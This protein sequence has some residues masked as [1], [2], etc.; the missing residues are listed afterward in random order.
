MLQAVEPMQVDV[1]PESDQ[2]AQE[3][4]FIVESATLVMLLI[5]YVILSI[6]HFTVTHSAISSLSS[7]LRIFSLFWATIILESLLSSKALTYNHI[8]IHLAVSST[9]LLAVIQPQNVC[10]R[11]CEL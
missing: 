4:N 6:H 1:A 3:D 2:L 10:L 9:C 11:I 7:L 8:I 5:V